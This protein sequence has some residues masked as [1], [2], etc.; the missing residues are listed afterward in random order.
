MISIHYLSK[1]HICYRN[2]KD[3]GYSTIYDITKIKFCY[4]RPSTTFSL[5]I[6]MHNFGDR[7]CIKTNSR[8]HCSLQSDSVLFVFCNTTITSFGNSYR[9]IIQDMCWQCSYI[10]KYWFFYSYINWGTISF[11]HTVF[12]K[13]AANLQFRLSLPGL[14]LLCSITYKIY[15]TKKHIMK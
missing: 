3:W 14:K 15:R 10:F 2:S 4:V 1:K 11:S 6:T 5:Y 9:N 7:Y 12:V 8:W 13:V